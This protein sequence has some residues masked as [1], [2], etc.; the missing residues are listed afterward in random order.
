MIDLKALAKPRIYLEKSNRLRLSELITSSQQ[1]ATLG[2]SPKDFPTISPTD[3]ASLA[4][5]EIN[6]SIV[7]FALYRPIPQSAPF[8]LGRIGRFLR[9]CRFWN[10]GR[11]FIPRDL[12]LLWIDVLP[13][14]RRQGIGRALV[15]K[16]H[17]AFE[18]YARCIQAIVPDG[19]LPV[20]LLLRD[21]GY[22]AVRI[23]PN[24][25]GHND[26]YLMERPFA[27]LVEED[28]HFQPGI[29]S[30]RRFPHEV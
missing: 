3:G 2:W 25:F 15:Q 5:A 4:L 12:E 10:W 7:G 1:T 8:G 11:R 22:Q 27:N 16:I 21:A 24:Y 19:N 9:W 14:W 30:L 29:D 13:D 17:R 18:H 26:G 28:C 23:L 6:G 20:Q